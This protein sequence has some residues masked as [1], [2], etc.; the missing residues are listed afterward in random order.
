MAGGFTAGMV[1][2][3]IVPTGTGVAPKER[4]REATAPVISQGGR[5]FEFR[6]GEGRDRVPGCV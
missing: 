3:R 2:G 1:M 5:I 6:C 4:M